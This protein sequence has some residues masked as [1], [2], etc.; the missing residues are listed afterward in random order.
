M[1]SIVNYSIQFVT[2]GNPVESCKPCECLLQ[3]FF[4]FAGGVLVINLF[5]YGYAAQGAFVIIFFICNDLFN[6]L[7]SV[8][9]ILLRTENDQNRVKVNSTKNIFT[10]SSHYL[11]FWC[12]P[13]TVTQEISSSSKNIN[14]TAC[15]PGY[16]SVSVYAPK[17]YINSCNEIQLRHS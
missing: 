2:T 1:L 17:V 6:C 8:C 4:S 15:V 14:N 13:C 5:Y 11:L 12:I 3:S 16:V 10:E 9:T 7:K